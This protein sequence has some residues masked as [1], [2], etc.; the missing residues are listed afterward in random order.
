MISSLLFFSILIYFALFLIIVKK[1]NENALA[2]SSS[3]RVI[4][5]WVLIYVLKALNRIF[6]FEERNLFRTSPGL[7]FISLPLS[8]VLIWDRKGGIRLRTDQKFSWRKT[9]FC[10][11]VLLWNHIYRCHVEGVLD[12]SEKHLLFAL[13]LWMVHFLLA[14]VVI[15]FDKIIFDRLLQFEGLTS[16][17]FYR[18]ARTLATFALCPFRVFRKRSVRFFSFTCKWGCQKRTLKSLST[19]LWL[20]APWKRRVRNRSFALLLFACL[21]E[22]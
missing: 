12:P 9:A 21:G 4:F 15:Y 8:F 22:P 3:A 13:D 5:N 10:Q 6:P 11:F 19:F 2:S 16:N 1:L 18:A 14:H 7:V 17:C 20:F